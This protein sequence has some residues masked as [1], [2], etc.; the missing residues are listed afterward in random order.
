[1]ADTKPNTRQ[2]ILHERAHQIASELPETC[3][4]SILPGPPPTTLRDVVG[5]DA[6]AP[7]DHLGNLRP[8]VSD[9]AIIA[10]TGA[11]WVRINFILGPWHSVDDTTRHQGRTWQETYRQLIDGFRAQGLRIYGLIG[12][13]AVGDPGD[14]F[15]S[16][17]SSAAADPWID[18]Y[19]A[20]F[21]TVLEMFAA[22]LDVVESFNE[23]NDWHRLPDT[24]WSQAWI[25]PAW[26]AIMLQQLYLAVKINPVIAHIPL[27]SGPLL[28]LEANA[29]ALGY[30]RDT[31]AAGMAR[32]AWGTDGNP[33]PFDAVGL[34]LY[35]HEGA[36]TWPAQEKAVRTTYSRLLAGIK[37]GIWEA[38]KRP[39]P[40]VIS[41]MGWPSDGGKEEQQAQ[42]IVLGLRLLA[43]DP[44]VNLA[45]AFCTQD[46]PAKYYGFFP[47]GTL[48][49]AAPKPAYY[50]FQ[51]ACTAR[52]VEPAVEDMARP[53][54][55]PPG[56]TNQHVIGAFKTVS[57]A[58]QLGN[59]GLMSRAGLK[60]NALV[61]RRGAPYQGPTIDDLPN[62]T[63]AQR[64]QVYELLARAVG[65]PVSLV[66]KQGWLLTQPDVATA[67]LAFPA[68]L[69]I[70][71]AGLPDAPARGVARTWNRYGALLV[72]IADALAIDVAVATAVL[73]LA[74]GGHRHTAH[75]RLWIRFE[76]PV[77]YAHWG[78]AHA[79]TFADHFRLDAVRSW[80]QPHWRPAESTRW[81]P[82]H[83]GQAAEWAALTTAL[84]LD[85]AAAFA[86]TAMGLPRIMGFNHALA[87][88]GTAAE[89]FHAFAASTRAQ[90]VA[91]FDLLAGPDRQSRPVQALQAGDLESFAALTAGPSAAAPVALAL[92]QKESLV[93]SYLHGLL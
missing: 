31:Y 87:G 5:V 2:A 62:L 43:H 26:F 21:V 86:A 57:L 25:D 70:P 12:V 76:V 39:K 15:R 55:I 71:L 90:V 37:Q 68:A 44:W 14:R 30:L 79:E 83:A 80:Q 1:M 11:G 52:L 29:G 61:A 64:D 13:E 22:D 7:I 40:I 3:V 53:R 82:V 66:T 42:S 9:P 47:A 56:V 54:P 58:H 27:V 93:S 69:H 46:F 35:V 18:R 20:T 23:P 33:F 17:P 41:E 45:V 4:P 63:A 78:R 24:T 60:L 91:C 8:Q 92:R 28:G 77:F 34:H 6:N 74:H 50:V 73:A 72:A 59:W 32:F 16:A 48:P 89:M 81:Q 36:Q 75:G 19:V 10:G 88:Y 38:E 67:A 85:E 51:T 65:G 49:G 84:A